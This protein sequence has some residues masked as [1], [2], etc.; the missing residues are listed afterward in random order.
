MSSVLPPDYQTPAWPSILEGGAEL[1]LVSDICVFTLLWTLVISVGSSLLVAIYASVSLRWAFRGQRSS[2]PHV[3]PLNA[4]SSTI[5]PNS[6]GCLRTRYHQ[7]G[8]TY[9]MLPPS[10]PVSPLAPSLLNVLATA[11]IV[12]AV[13]ATP[14]AATI[15]GGTVGAAVGAVYGA[16]GM[17][18]MD[19]RVAAA[20]GAASSASLWLFS[21]GI[22]TTGLL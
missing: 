21:T 9:L 2:A 5:T 16:G 8:N 12:L 18:P 17:L 6:Q 10:P 20:W 11:P 4:V 1:Y 7:K 13:L 14:I 3:F 22:L 15:V 19:T